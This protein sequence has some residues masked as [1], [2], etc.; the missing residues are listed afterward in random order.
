MQVSQDM[1]LGGGVE[2]WER[3]WRALR[4]VYRGEYAETRARRWWSRRDREIAR[5][6]LRLIEAR[7]RDKVENGGCHDFPLRSA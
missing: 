5:G 2:P 3:V 6:S 4:G 7:A 1:R